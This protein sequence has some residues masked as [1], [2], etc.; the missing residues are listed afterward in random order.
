MRNYLIDFDSTFTQV[1]A[2]D[3]LAAIAL[4]KSPDRQKVISKVKQITEMGM[5][6]K[7]SIEDSLSQRLK[8]L[9][10]NQ[11][12]LAALIK[13]LKRRI[14]PSIKR[15]RDFFK[16][17]AKQVFILSS[18][19]KEFIWPV[20][21]DFNI[22][23]ANVLANSLTFDKRGNITGLDPTNPLSRE[24]GKAI[25]VKSLNLAGEKYVIGDG[26]TDM[27]T[28]DLGAADKFFAFVENVN[29]EV[30]AK[31]ADH[32]VKSFDEF[33]YINGLQGALSYPKNRIH[34]LLLESVHPVAVSLLEAEGYNVET[35]SKALGETEL[36]EKIRNVSLLGIRSKTQISKK[37]L[38][39][40]P[41]L[42]AVGA[43]CIGTD[44]IDLKSSS[45]RGVTVFNAPYSNTRSVVELAIGEI[46]MLIRRAFEKSQK[47]HAGEWD[48]SATGSFEIRGKKLG[49]VGYG[50]IGAQLSVIAE[51]L[52]MEVYY[53]DIVEKL[54]LG[55]AKKCQS[56]GE[57]LS[58]ADI[59]SVHVDGRASNRNLIG[60][61]E[62]KAMKDGIIFLN[63][64]RGSIVD[65]NALVNA[66][67]S[68]KVA[69]VGVDVY[70]Y[71]P[72]SNKEEFVSELRG[73]P[74]VIMTPHIGGSTLEAQRNI[75]EFVCSNL[76][77]Y[78]NSGDTYSS[79]NFPSI[80]LPKIQDAHRLLHVHE[81]VPG[82][83]A[84]ING[85]LAAR[86]INVLG[87]YLKT[88]DA[89]GYVITDV[90]KKYDENVIR[91][92]R[93]IDHTIKFRVLY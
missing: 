48:K 49:I 15:N 83:L 69:G 3:E 67:K 81:N 79:V 46:I 20:V 17:N 10:A 43:F 40:A 59:I 68:G 90:N 52:G 71:E 12:H 37:V 92:L 4:K 91:D 25:R 58:K 1:E 85:I 6:G 77:N 54:S 33:L 80:A 30:V 13:L 14:T 61:R 50:N 39:A 47:L 76:V 29:R 42:M 87:Q 70:P 62:F 56:L 22:P 88:T 66:V 28:R 72:E 74:N 53:Y 38:E 34:A 2:L 57:L 73:L 78:V 45:L 65:V 26:F 55:N 32:V 21:K 44:Q 84:K 5:L 64:S 8:L 36:I 27:Q 11:T 18:G 16:K 7:L 41:R 9:K 82:I 31:G 35:V 60:A 19:F 93:S 51:S 86:N 75:A 63:L 89:I 24:G 23:E